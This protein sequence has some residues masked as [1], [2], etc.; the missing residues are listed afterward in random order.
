MRSAVWTAGDDDGVRGAWVQWQRMTE[1]VAELRARLE[2][3]A[4]PSV[5][6]VTPGEGSKEYDEELTRTIN[7]LLGSTFIEHLR[8]RLAKAERLRSDIN[9]KL[10]QNPT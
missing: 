4:G 6:T 2:A 10:A 5:R 7:E 1:A 8:D 9:A 3:L